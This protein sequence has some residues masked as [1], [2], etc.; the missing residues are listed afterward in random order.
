MNPSIDVDTCH[1]D[2]SQDCIVGVPQI[3]SALTV[4]MSLE[5][6]LRQAGKNSQERMDIGAAR[7]LCVGFG[8][9]RH[10]RSLA[11]VLG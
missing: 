3:L 5:K 11:S 8:D 1:A 9:G 7:R 10:F 6:H 2:I 4:G